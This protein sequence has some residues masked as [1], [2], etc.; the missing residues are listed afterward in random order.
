MIFCP[1]GRRWIGRYKNHLHRAYYRCPTSESESWRSACPARFSFRQEVIET[2]IWTQV[3]A[4]L[5]HP[6][7][8]F[9]EVARQREQQA[10]ESER[11]GHLRG[12]LESAITDVDRKLGALLHVS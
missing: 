9:A 2:A 12:A 4:Y 5:L 10:A 3:T 7:T 8:L 1:C 6:E 11:R